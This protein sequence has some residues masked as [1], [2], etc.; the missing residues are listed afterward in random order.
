MTLTRRA[1]KAKVKTT[2]ELREHVGQ[3]ELQ[4][5]HPGQWFNTRAGDVVRL[6]DITPQSIWGTR[7]KQ[8]A[9]GKWVCYGTR[10][11]NRDGRYYHQCGTSLEDLTRR[12]PKPEWLEGVAA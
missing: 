5:F 4:R 2:A 10:S 9:C 1:E 6:D 8:Y 12:I 11:W 7:W 3:G